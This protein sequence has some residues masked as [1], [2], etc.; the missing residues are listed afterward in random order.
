MKRFW[1]FLQ[2]V[3]S[4]G[5]PESSKRFFGSIGWLSAIIIIYIWRK[6]LTE[7]LLYVSAA[8]IGFETLMNGFN[9]FKKK[10]ENKPE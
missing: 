7:T 8:L 9:I 5:S 6:D 1:Q 10:D 2:G 4:S 3:Y